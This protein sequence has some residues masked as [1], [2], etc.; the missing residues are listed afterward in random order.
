[1]LTG[2]PDWNVQ[3]TQIPQ[4]GLTP[5][6]QTRQ[7]TAKEALKPTHTLWYTRITCTQGVGR[8]YEKS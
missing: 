3:Q 5:Q 2:Q 1:M 4:Q 7:A 8:S 6:T